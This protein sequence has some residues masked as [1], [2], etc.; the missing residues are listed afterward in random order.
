M[1]NALAITFVAYFLI[2]AVIGFV[3]WRR[4]VTSSDYVLGG[5]RLSAPVA[6]LSAGASDMSGWLM[7]GLP[8]AVYAVGI[9]EAWIVVG[10]IV[11][12]YLNWRLVAPRLREFS[13]ATGAQTLPELFARRLADA[14]P[15][16]RITSTLLILFFF[17]V[18][19][20]SGF[21]SGAKLFSGMLPI[22]YST[23]LWVGIVAIMLY[24]TVGGFLAVSWTDA[25]QALLMVAALVIVPALAWRTSGVGVDVDYDD[26]A[27]PALSLASLLAWGLGYFGQPHIV[28]RFMALRA[29]E[30]VASARRT[31]MTWMVLCC[32]GAVSVGIAGHAWVAAGA[33]APKDPEM[34]FIQMTRLLLN[35]WFGGFVLA[36]IL[37]AIMSTVSSQ[38][39]VAS[40]CLAHDAL[41]PRLANA[42]DR[43]ILRISQ[44]AVVAT[45]LVAGAIAMDPASGVL[46]LVAYAW[47]GL[48]ASLGPVLLCTLFWS[49]MTRHGAIA[50]MLA[51]AITVVIWGA[52]DG[53]IFDLYELLPGFIAGA[54]AI[55]AVSVLSADPQAEHVFGTL[56][57]DDRAVRASDPVGP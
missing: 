23:A 45:T 47:A 1:T 57:A 4:T 22:D 17:T 6:A 38:L 13:A 36:A 31:G 33:P 39:L 30:S 9:G 18:Y 12:A 27:R 40:T 51:G 42:S 11:G 24:T 28:V 25:F 10:L 26:L 41:R 55:V 14:S 15:W 50:G 49:R 20:A 19:T 29:D 3:A 54:L 34:I 32:A 5:R 35:P 7:L 56:T 52:L 21:V 53:G 48:G 8:G 37:A 2:L 16:L 43:T 44:A 46:A